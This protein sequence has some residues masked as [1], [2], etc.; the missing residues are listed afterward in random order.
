MQK[1][2]KWNEI[3]NILNGGEIILWWKF[4]DGEDRTGKQITVITL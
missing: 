4:G 3:T 1:N 2:K